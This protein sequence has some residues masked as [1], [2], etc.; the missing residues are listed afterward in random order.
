MGDIN[1]ERHASVNT[2]GKKGNL[3]LLSSRHMESK[4]Q[5]LYGSIVGSLA[6]YL[7]EAD[8]TT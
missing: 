8:S 1:D 5:T 7:Q 4:G 2:F 6:L 3:L